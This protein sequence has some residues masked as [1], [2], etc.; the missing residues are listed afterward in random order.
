MWARGFLIGMDLRREAWQ[1]LAE[2]EEE[3]EVLALIGAL[4]QD[5]MG[6]EAIDGETREDVLNHLG[7]MVLLIDR[8]WRIGAAAPPQPV[9]SSKVGRNAPCPCGSG[10]KYK[11]CC[12]A[13]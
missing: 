11:K 2:A 7:A 8:Y 9:R 4:I 3:G 12:G 1:S 5:E 10:R 13:H 6:D